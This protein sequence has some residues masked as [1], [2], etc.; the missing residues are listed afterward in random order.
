MGTVG[1]SWHYQCLNR[2]CNYDFYTE[3]KIKDLKETMCPECEEIGT[4]TAFKEKKKGD[5]LETTVEPDP[6]EDYE[7]VYGMYN[8]PEH[9]G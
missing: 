4:I 2:R 7:D 8:L 6:D 1:W 5:K 3:N 9:L